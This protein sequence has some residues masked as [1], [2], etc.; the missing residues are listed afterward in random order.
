MVLATALVTLGACATQ[1]YTPSPDAPGF[2]SGL[3]HGFLSWFALIAHIFSPEIR[4]Y[5]DP[6]DGGWY[7][8]GFL[9]GVTAWGGIAAAIFD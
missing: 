5:A 8:C 9:L 3:L 6:N 4:I 1:P 7:D 2:V